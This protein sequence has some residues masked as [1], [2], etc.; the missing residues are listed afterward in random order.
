M[1]II[2]RLNRAKKNK[3]NQTGN[4]FFQWEFH[5]VNMQKKLLKEMPFNAQREWM[6]SSLDY[7]QA[8]KYRTNQVYWT[9]GQRLH[10]DTT[11]RV[12]NNRTSSLK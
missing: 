2:D 3:S 12:E 7:F 4:V 1:Y 10:F 9:I 6:N 8:I 11:S 5:F